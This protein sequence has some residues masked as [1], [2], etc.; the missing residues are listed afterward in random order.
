MR[1]IKSHNFNKSKRMSAKDN[2]NSISL[3][4]R[5]ELVS[6]TTSSDFG[7]NC[8]ETPDWHPPYVET[9]DLHPPYVELDLDPSPSYAETVDLH[10]IPPPWSDEIIGWHPSVGE[11]SPFADETVICYP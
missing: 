6:P 5:S 3:A 11:H 4:P 10:L 1:I 2:E 8:I 7:F 9:P